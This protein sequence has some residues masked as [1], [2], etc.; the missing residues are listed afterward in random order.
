MKY[1]L[2]AGQ[3]SFVVVDGQF[4]GKRFLR[5]KTYDQGRVPMNEMHRFEAVGGDQEAMRVEP[6]P[7]VYLTDREPEQEGDET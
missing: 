3:E 4:T 2:R 5:G 6:A 7:V 1:R